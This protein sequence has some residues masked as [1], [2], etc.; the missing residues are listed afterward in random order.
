MTKRVI[1]ILKYVGLTSIVFFSIISCEKEIE[2]IGVNIIENNKFQTGDFVTEVIGGNVNIE[3]VPSN[4][5]KQYL[6][7]VYS[8]NEFGELKG[9]LVSQIVLPSTGTSYDYGD[10]IVVDSVLIDIPYQYTQED[11]DSDGKPVFEIDSVFG[12]PDI[13]FKL[14]VFRL[15]TFINSLDPSNPSKDMVYYSDK[16]WE[17]SPIPFYVEDFKINPNDTVSYIKR[18]MPDGVVYQ[19]DTIKNLNSAPSIK[20]PLNK[21]MIKEIFI[22]NA[23]GAE[24]ASQEDFV[25]YFK[26]FYIEADVAS[27]PMSH[28]VSLAMTAAK[29]TIYYSNTDDENDNEDLNN[30]GI[31][32]EENV[33][34]PESYNFLF[35]D[36]KSSIYRRNYTNSKQSGPER[37]YVQG[38]AGSL[39]TIQ[40]F[41]NNDLEDINK[42]EYLMTGANL[43]LHVDQDAS[44]NIIPD[45]LFI[46]NYTENS[47]IVDMM[48]EGISVVGGYLERDT[49]GKPDKYVFKIAGLITQIL[50]SDNPENLE[51][52][53]IKVYNPTDI[54]TSTTDT[55]VSTYS[56][57]PQGVVLYNQNPTFGD[58][59]AKLEIY[60]SKLNN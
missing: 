14:S 46:Y 10:N 41:P 49:D 4:K 35:A 56:W 53:A 37:L 25:H 29:M 42:D 22:D 33:R 51:T 31:N 38:A 47:Q 28:L 21:E 13:A 50:N 6:L 5:I 36:N 1:A 55:I 15:E 40:L 52:L 7:G 26:G 43:I 16:V 57:I 19:I 54:A 39:A 8:D 20:I 45:Q 9:S 34:V 60:Y 23:S 11:D 27:S 59:R 2:N 3:K 44:S 58:K 17:K 24:F 12:N 32:G 18:H 30:N 48:D